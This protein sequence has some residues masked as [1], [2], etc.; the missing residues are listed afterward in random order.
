M[1][2]E[3]IHIGTYMDIGLKKHNIKQQHLLDSMLLEN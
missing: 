3:D 1:T 2:Q